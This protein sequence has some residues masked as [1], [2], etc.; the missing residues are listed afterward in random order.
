VT[1]NTNSTSTVREKIAQAAEESSEQLQRFF[2]EALAADRKVWSSCPACS[3]RHEVEIPDWNARTK[4][5]ETMLNQGFG[6]PKSEEAAGGQGFIL[7]RIIVL[8][9]G[10]EHEPPAVA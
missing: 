4:V 5:V 6:R 3:K 10:V 2:E 7:K 9:G 8:P 1:E